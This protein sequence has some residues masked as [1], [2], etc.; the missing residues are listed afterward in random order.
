MEKHQVV[1]HAQR[2][3]IVQH[4]QVQVQHVQADIQVQSELLMR[5]NAIEIA[6]AHHEVQVVV[7]D[8]AVEVQAKMTLQRML[9]HQLTLQQTLRKIAVH[10]VFRN[11]KIIL[12]EHKKHIQKNSNQHMNLLIRTELQ[13]WIQLKKQKWNHH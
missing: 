8:E 10:K 12:S 3:V 11:Q 5:V 6:L 1:Q 9:K 13:Q 7:E 2:E 4:E